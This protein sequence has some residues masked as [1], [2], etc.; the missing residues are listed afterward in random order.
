MSSDSNSWCRLFHPIVS[1]WFSKRYGNATAVQE[2]AWPEIASGSHVLVCSPT[3]SGKTMTAFLYFLNMLLTGKLSGGKT[4]IL[5]ISPLKALNNDIKRNLLEPLDVLRCAFASAG[6]DTPDINVM[7]RSGDTEPKDRRL[8]LKHPPEI[9]IT[10]PESLNILLTSQSGSR[11]LENVAVVIMDEIHAVYGS[12]RGTHLITAVERLTLLCGEFQRIAL[13]ATVNPIQAVADFI[14]GYSMQKNSREVGYSKRNVKV[15]APAVSKDYNVSVR[16]PA[17]M[18]QGVKTESLWES[19]SFMLA[20]IVRENTSTILFANGRRTVERLAH[21]LNKIDNELA[22]AHHGSL[23]KEIRLL[24]EEKLKSGKIRGIVATNS[25]EL[26]IDIGHCDRIIMIQSPAS[27]ASAIQRLGR[28]GHKVGDTS[29]GFIIPLKGRDFLDAAVMA[30]C[31]MERDIEPAF[32]IAAPLDVLAQVILSMCVERV[33]DIDELYVFIRCAYPYHDLKREHFDLVLAMLEG[34]YANSKIRGLTPKLSIDRVDNTA[35]A[36]GGVAWQLYLSGGTI[37]DRGYYDLRVADTRAKIG[38]LDEE[39]VWERSEGDTFMFGTQS[40]RIVDITHNDVLAVPAPSAPGIIPFWR[41]GEENRG[42]FFMQR[43][44]SFLETANTA[45]LNQKLFAETLTK[46]YYMDAESAE[47]LAA[48]CMS[49][50]SESGAHLPHRHHILIEKII[51]QSLPPDRVQLVL[52]TFWGGRLNSPFCLALGAAWSERFGERLDI[53]YNNDSLLLSNFPSGYEPSRIFELVRG[54]KLLTLIR[55]GLE[56]SGI[57]GAHFRENAARSLLLPKGGFKKRMPLWLNRQRSK[58]LLEAV[59]NYDDFPVLLETWRSCIN[60]EFELDNLAARLNEI[61]FA[62]TSVSVTESLTPSPFAAGIVWQLTNRDMYEDDKP[63]ADGMSGLKGS[64]IREAALTSHLRPLVSSELI[65]EL[66]AKLQRTARGFAPETSAELLDWVKERLLI[67]A[68]EWEKLIEEVSRLASA[69]EVLEPVKAKLCSIELPNALI[70][71]IAAVESLPL[72]CSA[73]VLSLGDINAVSLFGGQKISGLL[74]IDGG[75]SFTDLVSQWLSYYGPVSVDFVCD[76]FGLERDNLFSQ[77]ESLFSENRLVFDTFIEG[78]SEELCDTENLER[79]L[80]MN[81]GSLSPAFEALPAEYLQFFLARWQ[82]LGQALEGVDGLRKVMDSLVG[83]P[84]SARS[85]EEFIFPAR[86][87]PYYTNMLDSFIA[88]E[89]LEWLGC[90]KEKIFFFSPETRRLFISSSGSS[91]AVLNIFP[92]RYGAFNLFDLQ[93]YTG[94]SMSDVSV[95]LWELA[96]NGLVNAENFAVLRNGLLSNFTASHLKS[97]YGSKSVG[98]NANRNKP[99]EKI[100]WRPVPEVF[101]DDNRGLDLLELDEIKRELVRQ[102]IRRYGIIFREL[103]ERELGFAAWKNIF[104][105]LRLMELSGELVTGYFFVGIPG[106]QFMSQ[107]SFRALFNGSDDVVFWMNAADPVSLCGIKVPELHKNFPPRLKSNF[108]VFCGPILKL[109]LRRNGLEL[110]IYTQPDDSCLPLY[111]TVFRDLTERD[112]EPMSEIRVE[113]INE[114]P[115]SESIYKN[116]LLEFGFETAYDSLVL[117]RRY[118]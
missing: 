43:I 6:I 18:R 14:G 86:I 45:C 70:S 51:N 114:K 68:G 89:G 82:G 47:T 25:L 44:A 39:F 41:S 113:K 73:F 90:G 111:L 60:D 97:K 20:E 92:L 10:T 118:E 15:I 81:R 22:W 84:A 88:Q 77:L 76:V 98:R 72:I 40:W 67:P 80:R 4:R 21:F 79:L 8:M 31:I 102:L 94:L 101:E 107:S 110:T 66:Q 53:I 5:Y 85:F 24:V 95:K 100:L 96:W 1:D 11:L 2:F 46:D 32:S 65:E 61:R 64:L 71:C 99:F 69:D 37:P 19:L 48:Y 54:E 17:G 115:A 16:F 78:K 23:S 57:F 49:Q 93:K 109:E 108:L 12:K 33:W 87:S 9:L 38:E 30:R 104:R 58:N 91:E 59:K 3:G 42:Y 116:I 52:H 112:F 34:R 83:F 50:R 75:F 35:L 28:A 74:N 36:R 62:E 55:K 117:K 27:V 103:L 26:G 63:L 7:T 106:L 105:T 56:A 29:R 13:S